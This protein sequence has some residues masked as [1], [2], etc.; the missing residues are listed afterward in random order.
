MPGM[1]GSWYRLKMT[2]NG[3]DINASVSADG[4]STYTDLGTYTDY[5]FFSGKVGI[6]GDITTVQYDDINVNCIDST[7]ATVP[8]APTIGTATR[9]NGQATVAF[10]A[11][12]S[13]GGSTITSYTATSTPGEYNRNCKSSRFRFNN[14]NRFNKRNCLHFQSKSNKLCWNRF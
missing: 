9:G 6:A 7:T 10:T 4:G 1:R 11:P 13:D 12:A 3:A 5:S 14:S 2:F 8:D